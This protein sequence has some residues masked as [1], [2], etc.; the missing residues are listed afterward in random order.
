MKKLEYE[1]KLKEIEAI[2]IGSKKE[3]Y[4]KYAL[5]NAKFKI[6]DLIKDSRWCFIIDKILVSIN[7]HFPEPVYYGFELK[8]DLTPKKK[9][10]R[11]CIYGNNAELIIPNNELITPNK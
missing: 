3:L 9:N 4:R 7:S 2:Y 11:V 6:G 10:N 1:D 5:I 8:K